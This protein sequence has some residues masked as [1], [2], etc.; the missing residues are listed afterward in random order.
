MTYIPKRHGGAFR[1]CTP[2]VNSARP[3][4]FLATFIILEA[5]V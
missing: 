5:K 4:F 2:P 3:T 1:C